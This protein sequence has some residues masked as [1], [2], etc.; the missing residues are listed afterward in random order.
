LF[1]DNKPV[2]VY[3]TEKPRRAVAPRGVWDAVVTRE[4]W[5]IPPVKM[6]LERVIESN[7]VARAQTAVRLYHEITRRKSSL[8]V[9]VAQ[10]A[11]AADVLGSDSERRRARRCCDIVGID[12]AES[13]L[14]S[15]AAMD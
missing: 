4:R 7:E 8:N 3:R 11:I 5:L 13:Y 15:A 12:D 2:Y 10:F 14:L 1:G 9:R 6:V